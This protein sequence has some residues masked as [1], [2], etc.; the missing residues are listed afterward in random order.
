LVQD[1]NG[2]YPGITIVKG[3]I[4]NHLIFSIPQF[5][6]RNPQFDILVGAGPCVI[7]VGTFERLNVG[8]FNVPALI[9]GQPQG[10]A[11]TIGLPDVVH[12]F[13]I[14]DGHYPGIAI[15]KGEIR[16]HLIFSIPHFAFRNSQSHSSWDHILV[17]AGPCA[18]PYFWATTG[19]CP[20]LTTSLDTVIITIRHLARK[21][22]PS[23]DLP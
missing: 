5:A 11:P 7:N 19:G 18:C 22:R 6:F 12:R 20:Y 3:E 2:H 17:G 21:I 13:E 1:D 8:T 4:R 15:V 10:V 23:A 14:D 16:N 9:F